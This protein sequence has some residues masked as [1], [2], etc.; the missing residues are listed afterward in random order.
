MKARKKGQ[1]LRTLRAAGLTLASADRLAAQKGG[2]TWA[3]AGVGIAA[4]ALMA[5]VGVYTMNLPTAGATDLALASPTT[6]TVAPDVQPAADVP[7]VETV[8]AETVA[9]TASAAPSLP[10]EPSELPWVVAL[11][12][13]TNEAAAPA[14]VAPNPTKATDCVAALTSDVSGVVLQFAPGSADIDPAAQPRL[15]ELGK[16]INACPEAQVQVAGHSDSSGDDLS[17]L[18]LSWVRAENTVNAMA[19]YGTDISQMEAVGFGSRVPLE[20]GSDAA[21]SL[22]RRVEIRVMRAEV[23]P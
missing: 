6:Q 5:G 18:Q 3:L 1:D 19:A 13:A 8:K 10:D 2:S 17:N 11:R 12:E 21:S 7:A 15:S 16:R 9:S 23:R 14:K 4:I 22:N 20:Q